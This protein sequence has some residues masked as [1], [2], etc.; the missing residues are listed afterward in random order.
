[1]KLKSRQEASAWLT[2]SIPEEL[3]ENPE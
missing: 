2:K 1:L 3:R